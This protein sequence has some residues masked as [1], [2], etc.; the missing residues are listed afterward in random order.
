[1]FQS[2]NFTWNGQNSNEIG[3]MLV[4]V[5]ID[6]TQE[7]FVTNR[8][9]LSD[10]LQTNSYNYRTYFY[11]IKNEPM[12]FTAQ[13]ASET[14]ITQNRINELSR[15]FYLNSFAP[16]IPMDSNHIYN[17]ICITGSL[18]VFANGYYCSFDFICDSPFSY[19]NN[20]VTNYNFDSIVS[21]TTFEINNIGDIPA[22]PYM[23]I[24]VKTTGQNIKI[25][26]NT[27]GGKTIKLETSIGTQL[28]ADETLTI[29]FKKNKISSSLETENVYRYDNLT[30]DGFFELVRGKNIIQVDYPCQI[31]LY[32]K[33]Q[34]LT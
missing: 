34:Y 32:T 19:S 31:K 22:Y 3:L 4:K 23:E 33:W 27:N 20:Y 13:F 16:F 8:N 28:Y 30:S 26:N 2:V 25:T 17:S 29:D 14:V 11:S 9:I 5:D 18:K 24:K 10:N 21:P 6:S 15:I 12:R 1:M 7:N